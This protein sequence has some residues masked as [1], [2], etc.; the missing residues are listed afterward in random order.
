MIPRLKASPTKA[1]TTRP[2]PANQACESAKVSESTPAAMPP[3]MIAMKVP[4]LRMPFP[5]DRRDSGSIAGNKLYLEGPK[6][7]LCKLIK[8]TTTSKTGRFSK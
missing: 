8:K 6:S 1:S 7:A 4:R 2:T 3:V 5:H